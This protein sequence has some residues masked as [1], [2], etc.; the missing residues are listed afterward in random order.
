LAGQS[1]CSNCCLNGRL[2][3]CYSEDGQSRGNTGYLS[4]N[5]NHNITHLV[6]CHDLAPLMSTIITSFAALSRALLLGR[7]CQRDLGDRPHSEEVEEGLAQDVFGGERG[8]GDRQLR[9]QQAGRRLW[10][11]SRRTKILTLSPQSSLHFGEYPKVDQK[12]QLEVSHWFYF[13][14]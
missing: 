14:T 2:W 9:A 7:G 11:R 13:L 10:T 6:P 8:E 5:E 1:H 12:I 4:L 3:L